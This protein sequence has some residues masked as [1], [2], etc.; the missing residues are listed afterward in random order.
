[1]D[2]R[3]WHDLDLDDVFHALDHAVSEPGR[4]YLYHI[5]RSPRYEPGPLERLSRM[6]ERFSADEVAASEAGSR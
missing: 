4:Q 1:V 5:L 6:V 3:T 2:D